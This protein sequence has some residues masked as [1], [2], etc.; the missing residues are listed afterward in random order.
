MPPAQ[1]MRTMSSQQVTDLQT[2]IYGI[3]LGYRQAQYHSSAGTGRVLRNLADPIWQD[4]V[5]Q[6]DLQDA[7]SR[8][9]TVLSPD[10]AKLRLF[11]LSAHAAY[12]ALAK[13]V[14][15]LQ[16][17]GMPTSDTL[18]QRWAAPVPLHMPAGASRVQLVGLVV[19]AGLG[20][21]LLARMVMR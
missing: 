12:D 16:D 11:D 18:L 3:T 20:A 9:A 15:V 1:I 14:G 21:Y 4:P 8:L 10:Q 17:D 6:T 13:M 5:W 7:W 19:G 2:V